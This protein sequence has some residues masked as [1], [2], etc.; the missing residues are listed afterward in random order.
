M[1]KDIARWPMKTTQQLYKVAT[2]CL[3]PSIQGRRNGICW[4]I[5]K[6]CS[7]K[8]LKCLYLARIGR[9]DILWSVNKFARAVTKWIRACDKR[10]ARLISYFHYTNEFK[11]Y[12]LVGKI[13]HNSA[14]YCFRTL[15]FQDT[16]KTQN[17]P[18]EDFCEYLEVIHS[19]Q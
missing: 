14:G 6:V 1:W 10:L 5:P 16:L 13:L 9:P 4:R 12:C 19:Y 15:T 11:Q 18:R 8:F 17:R 2:P 7:H 3:R